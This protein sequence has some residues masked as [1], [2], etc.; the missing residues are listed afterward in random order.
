MLDW[1]RG[2]DSDA[3]RGRFI[4]SMFDT[5]EVKD[6][7]WGSPENVLCAVVGGMLEDEAPLFE[8]R[9]DEVG[10]RRVIAMAALVE[11][12]I[13]SGDYRGGHRYVVF[14]DGSMTSRGV[15]RSLRG[16]SSAGVMTRERRWTACGAHYLGVGVADESEFETRVDAVPQSVRVEVESVVKEFRETEYIE[17]V[18]AV[19]RRVDPPIL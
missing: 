8:P 13:D 7:E 2:G 11:D 3:K 5:D 10:A 17:L 4:E 9:V 15:R 1:L 16:L 18:D 19:R 12:E 14:D 6:W